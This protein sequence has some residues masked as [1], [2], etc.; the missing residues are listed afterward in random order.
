MKSKMKRKRLYSIL[1]IAIL[2]V[3]LNTFGQNDGNLLLKVQ[4]KYNSYKSLSAD[5]IFNLH[6]APNQITEKTSARGK[7]YLGE[8]NKFRVELD[9][10][11]VVCDGKTFWNFKEEENK[12]IINNFDPND[13]SSFSIKT[14]LSEYPKKCTQEE[15]DGVIILTPKE[16]SDLDFTK[17]EIWVN[18]NNLIEKIWIDY[19]SW[20]A[21]EI[22][23]S[24]Y[25]LNQTIPDSKFT[26]TPPEGSKIIDLR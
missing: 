9:K 7:I 14:I 23:L 24:N 3:N 1:S 10:N 13:P 20:G 4:E 17:A 8:G 18:N 22:S 2:F 12:I 11:I 21:F 26:F 16:I 25:K 6:K 19:P 5:F 15:E